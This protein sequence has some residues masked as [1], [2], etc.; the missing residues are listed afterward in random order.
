MNIYGYIY[1]WKSRNTQSKW[2][3]NNTNNEAAALCPTAQ[4]INSDAKVKVTHLNQ[5]LAD[6]H[7]HR[8]S[9]NTHSIYITSG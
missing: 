7:T 8:H 1:I 9:I 3:D 2:G 5:Y 6:T 4:L